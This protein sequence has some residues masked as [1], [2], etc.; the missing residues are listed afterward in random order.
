MLI[1]HERNSRKR[2]V[3]S[4]SFLGC[5]LY[6]ALVNEKLQEAFSTEEQ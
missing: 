1:G 5:N 4:A 2:D 6:I 3:H